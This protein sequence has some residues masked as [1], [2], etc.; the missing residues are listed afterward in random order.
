MTKDKL[1]AQ[2]EAAI[3]AVSF[4][5]LED[6]VRG[7]RMVQRI[8]DEHIDDVLAQ[9]RVANTQVGHEPDRV[10]AAASP[11]RPVSA[12]R[13]KRKNLSWTKEA[14]DELIE[15]R[16]MKA[17]ASA[18]RVSVILGA[19]VTAKDINNNRYRFLGAVHSKINGSAAQ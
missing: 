4:M 7:A 3:Q 13:V 6:A 5:G 12:K 18:R 15:T 16:N 17:S 1:T 10:K 9:A 8:V 2:I 14:K 19:R 11:V